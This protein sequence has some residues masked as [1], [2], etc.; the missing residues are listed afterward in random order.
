LQRFDYA[1]VADLQSLAVGDVCEFEAHRQVGQV[2]N[3][4]GGA[5]R[6]G[7]EVQVVAF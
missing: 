7:D 3:L 2:V 6:D 4:R 5:D 1:A